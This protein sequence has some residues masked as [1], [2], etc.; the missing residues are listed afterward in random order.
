MIDALARLN[1][2]AAFGKE[3]AIPS[4][5]MFQY[6]F[7]VH[8]LVSQQDDP[9]VIDLAQRAVKAFARDLSVLTPALVFYDEVAGVYA[10]NLALGLMA[11]EGATSGFWTEAWDLPSTLRRADAVGLKPASFTVGTKNG[12]FTP[13]MLLLGFVPKR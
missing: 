9:K 1:E 12:V 6:R 11:K 7:N 8:M 4:G 13:K 2:T 10:A 5:P 3:L